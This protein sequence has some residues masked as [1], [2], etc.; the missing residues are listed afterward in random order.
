MPSKS[1]K[2]A[3]FMQAAARSPQIANKSD[4]P[5]R[6]AK[7]FVR[8]DVKTRRANMARALMGKK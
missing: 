4:I 6:V 2:Q 8:E 1:A 7:E 5:Q 3:R